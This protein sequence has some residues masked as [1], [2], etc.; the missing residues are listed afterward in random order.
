MGGVPKGADGPPIPIA[1]T[2]THPGISSWNKA[3]GKNI[4]L[5]SKQSIWVL[6]VGRGG[7]SQAPPQ[8][9]APV[10]YR[11]WGGSDRCGSPG[12]SHGSAGR[13]G[14][15]GAS[16]LGGAGPECGRDTG[17]GVLISQLDRV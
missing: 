17:W 10:F 13:D 9:I 6:A 8:E 16:E 4:P 1:H 15:D 11:I 7:L 12:L 2:H 14:G 3:G 5:T